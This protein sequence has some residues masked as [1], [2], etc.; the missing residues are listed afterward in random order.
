MARTGNAGWLRPLTE[1]P[2]LRLA[3]V[4][5]FY[6]FQG[7]PMGMF[8]FGVPAYMAGAG[9]SAGEIAAVVGAFSLPWTLK[10]VNG[11]FMDRYTFLPMG[12]RRV[13]IIG[14]QAAMVTVLLAG[15]VLAPEARDVALISALAFAVSMA[16]TFQDV[17]I[18]SLVVDIMDEN[19]QAKAGGIMFGAQILGMSLATAA[20]GFLLEHYGS[21]AAFGAGAL[22]LSGGVVFALLLRERPGERRWPWS[23]GQSHPRNLEIRIDA[24]LPLL[25]QSLTAILG[26]GSL[27]IIPFLLV[28]NVPGRRQ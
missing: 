4:F 2:I 24:W 17:A 23:E 15:A 7:L 21:R 27:L 28:R 9:A 19:D 16:T 8:Y 20:S 18:D 1:N 22:V 10:L 6:I 12:R 26:A 3:T 5:I 11:F 13:W 25:K 14:S